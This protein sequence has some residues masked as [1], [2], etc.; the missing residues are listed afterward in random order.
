MPARK[1]GKSFDT[2][3]MAVPVR[4]RPV[5]GNAFMPTSFV[6]HRPP[7]PQR[8]AAFT[9]PELLAVVAIIVIIISMLLPSLSRARDNAKVTICLA[10]YHTKAIALISYATSNRNLYIQGNPP[11][12]YFLPVPVGRE[13]RHHGLVTNNPDIPSDIAGYYTNYKTPRDSA[14]ICP[15]EQRV[16]LF[17]RDASNSGLFFNIYPNFPT[18]GL[19]GNPYYYGNNS[20]TRISDP[21]GPMLIESQRMSGGK[22][23]L[24]YHPNQLKSH[25]F[26]DGSVFSR[27]PNDYV[28]S[29]SSYATL[30]N[31]WGNGDNWYWLW[32]EK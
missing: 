15:N 13:L 20:P 24:T 1:N 9:V 17:H 16:L 8:T 29:G 3:L 32:A 28:K 31:V 30:M 22:L 2:S 5:A 10:N 27:G 7:S 21:R 11:G 6:H 25:A 19:K 4:T 12:P 26:S 18:T 14:W 23:A